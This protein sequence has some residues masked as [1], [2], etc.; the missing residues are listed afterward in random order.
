MELYCELQSPWR[1]QELLGLREL[2]K[3]RKMRSEIGS[4]F[5]R[6]DVTHQQVNYKYCKFIAGRLS[7]N[8][9]ALF[10]GQSVIGVHMEL[11]G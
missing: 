3:F 4:T 8:N 7:N 10:K 1:A 9:F 11:D 5:S 6:K 2:R